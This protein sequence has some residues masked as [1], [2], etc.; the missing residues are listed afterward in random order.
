MPL[1]AGLENQRPFSTL[2]TQVAGIIELCI[3]HAHRPVKSVK[4]MVNYLFF[5]QFLRPVTPTLQ[6]LG[7]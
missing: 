2:K 1:T 4:M 7:P 5:I 3:I 6:D